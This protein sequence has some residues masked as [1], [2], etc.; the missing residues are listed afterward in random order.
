MGRKPNKIL[1][2]KVIG[3]FYELRDL[4]CLGWILESSF[5]VVDNLIEINFLIK[6]FV[7]SRKSE[8]AMFQTDAVPASR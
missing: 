5:N 3:E 6:I 8:G 7:D 1:S 4:L 2:S